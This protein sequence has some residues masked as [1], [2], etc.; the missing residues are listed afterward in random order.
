MNNDAYNKISTNAHWKSSSYCYEN[1]TYYNAWQED[2]LWLPSVYEVGSGNAVDGLWRVSNEQRIT[3]GKAT[4]LRSA[5]S[6]NY[7]GATA[8]AS[9]GGIY[10]YLVNT[11]SAVARPALHLNLSDVENDTVRPL[12]TP[13]SFSK[14]YTGQPLTPD[15]QD[16]YTSSLNSAIQAG[17]VTEKY[18]KG[19]EELD[20]APTDVGTYTI[21][22]EIKNSDYKWSDQSTTKKIITFTIN[23]MTLADP[24]IK[25]DKSKQYNGSAGVTFELYNMYED[26][27]EVSISITYKDGTTSTY[28]GYPS[29]N[30]G[31]M[32]FKVQ[33]IGE[34]VV[35]VTPKENQC[36]SDGTQESRSNITLTVVPKTIEVVWS[37]NA[38]KSK[39]VTPK[40]GAICADDVGTDREPT[41]AISYKH[42]TTNV[43]YD[44]LPTVVG[45]YIAIA[46]ITN[47]CNYV[48]GNPNC[49]ER[50]IVDKREVA[51]P[52]ISNEQRIYKGSNYEIDLVNLVP[53]DVR[54]KVSD[55]MT[56]TDGDTK[57]YA[58]DAKTYNI[59]FTLKDA[60]NTKWEGTDNS[61]YFTL[62]VTITPAPLA[63][64]FNSDEWEWNN[65]DEKTVYITD[66]R[67][68]IDD[69]LT[70]DVSVDGNKLAASKV[71][72]DSVNK[73]DKKTNITIPSQI[74]GGHTLSV[75]LSAASGSNSNSNYTL[76]TKTQTFT[77]KGK[78]VVMDDSL[79]NWSYNNTE[80]GNPTEPVKLV[81]TG[82]AYI[83]SI[84]ES[85]LA[86][87][88]VKI[89]T[90]KSGTTNGYGGDVSATNA[91]TTA[92]SVTVYLT[93]LD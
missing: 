91:R 86:A 90:A 88:G 51:K 82:T 93:N 32:S 47:E 58:K 29:F 62:P 68:N 64:E 2:Y 21:E 12:S 63:I 76:T 53:A 36:W 20:T 83:F 78:R 80:V 54:V 17:N 16:W 13:K 15:G 72:W 3:S 73:A 61:G 25:G 69:V 85:P 38:D 28:S 60:D 74:V 55:G 79:I 56:Y 59:T 14:T 44:D 43:V 66:S 70:Y 41:F 57:V 4:W 34:Y 1:K 81:Y 23:K 89:D 87:C 42:Y 92:Y 39:S 48:L 33:E 26:F 8:I 10:A 19:T 49:N 75:A 11:T 27:V 24:S 84:N 6:N 35:T 7:H 31:V 46:T 5:R 30:N 77:I 18:Y 40:E 50:V 65:G 45:E 52:S 67:A 37:T 9:A 71:V 22:Y